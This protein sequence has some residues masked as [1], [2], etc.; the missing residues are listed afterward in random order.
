MNQ[1]TAFCGLICS[2]CGAFIATLDNDDDKRA[3]VAKL[4]SQQYQ[5]DLKP[6]DINCDGCTSDSERL[7]GHCFACEIRKCGKEKRV[8]NCA[9]CDDYVCDKLNSFFKMAPDARK[10]LD[11]I[12]N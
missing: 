12:R 1:I 11:S 6:S 10:N 2:E 5:V 9:Y 8:Q 7:I 3:E 4:W